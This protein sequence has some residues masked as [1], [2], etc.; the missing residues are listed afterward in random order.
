MRHIVT[1]VALLAC[2]AAIG[3]ESQTRYVPFLHSSNDPYQG[4]L[5]I[6]NHSNTS[7]EVSISGIDDEGT[8]YGPAT[9]LIHGNENLLLYTED[10][11]S[12]LDPVNVGLGHGVGSWRLHLTSSFDIEAIA[13]FE[14]RDGLL[15]NL[16]Q[17]V[18]GENGCW[19]IPM[20]YS[21]DN[22]TTSKVRLTNANATSAH[23]KISGRDDKG[24]ISAMPIELTIE[25]GVTRMF[26]SLQLEEGADGATGSLGNGRGNWQLAIESDKLITVMNLLESD[27]N[28][29]NIS[30]RAP[31]AIGHC[32]L[33]NTLAHADQS[34]INHILPYQEL[35]P[36]IYAAI[37]DEAGVRAIAATGV[38]KWGT[39]QLATVH[40]KLYLGS[41]TKPMTATMIASLIYA[42]SS[43]F[44]NG[45]NTTI[46]QA[47]INELDDI[48]LD[49][50]DVTIR[51]LVIH[52]SGAPEHLLVWEDDPELPKA[53]RRR[54]AALQ[55][56]ALPP[57][58]TPGSLAYSHTGYTIAAVM[59]EQLTGKS[60]ET[61][62]REHLFEPLGMSSAGFGPPVR[63]D[64]E[65]APWGHTLSFNSATDEETYEWLPTQDDWHEVLQPSVG[66][67]ASMQDLGKFVQLWMANKDP[68]LLNREQLQ[69]MTRL[70]VNEDG[71]IP[72]LLSGGSPSAGWWLFT[73][74][75]GFGESLNTPGSNGNWYAM[76]WVMRDISRAYIVVT[77]SALPDE[78]YGTRASIRGILTPIT[79]SLA[80]SP[81]RSEPPKLP[82]GTND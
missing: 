26:T 70:A 72:R 7:G 51:D 74:V 78:R 37:I 31:Y 44:E 38:K 36:A 4:V 13:Y 61:L 28:V 30:H 60:W 14:A 15:T 17:T 41:I 49:Y 47:F 10:I 81:A 40:D 19:R 63:T 55:L 64:S 9:I 65:N 66:V 57:A 50:H 20:F 18:Q 76:V 48:H 34:I 79:T 33:G 46:G 32:W 5:R 75:F 58:T 16:Q 2:I 3:Q 35:S 68:M 82:S 59:A 8:E 73:D 52:Y 54:N 6:I 22:L 25:P 62:M 71:A 11:E 67:H 45:W 1:A 21:A 53:E 29:T 39:D 43:V 23:V 80:S 24:V 77:N 42:E 69:A 12:G 56:L 27:R